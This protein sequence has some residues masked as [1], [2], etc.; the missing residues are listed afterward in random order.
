MRSTPRHYWIVALALSAACDGSSKTDGKDIRGA[1]TAGEEIVIGAAWPWS[2]HPDVLYRQGMEL[3]VAEVN[4]ARGVNGRS[5]RLKEL[6]DHESVD[7]GRMVAQQLAREPGVVAVIGHLQSYVTVPAAAIYDQAG[8]VLISATSTTPELTAHGYSRLFRTVFTDRDVG[9]QLAQYALARGHRQI[10]IYYM[11]NE[12]GLGL[13]NEFERAA[14]SGGARIVDRQSYDPGTPSNQASTERAVTAW[15]NLSIDAVFVA[16]QVP[17]AALFIAELRRKG[18]TAPIYGSDALGTPALL[19]IGGQAVEGTVLATAFHTGAPRAEVHRFSGAFR[20][21]YGREPDAGAALGYD[22]VNV[23]VEAIRRAG[24]TSPAKVSTALRAL[25]DWQGVT[26]PF[27]FDEHGDLRDMPV[28]KM[29]V[30]NGRFEYL[31]TE[32][33]LAAAR[34]GGAP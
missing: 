11:R 28:Q 24:S 1:P 23:L 19:A 7:D 13:A 16:G 21:A 20:H 17:Q 12:Y 3:A 10:A 32:V 5:L 31:P 14:T 9:A 8:I 6:D 29:V 30:R 34:T 2:A 27:T 15:K 26:G 22:A 4:A 33:G 25:K 18:I